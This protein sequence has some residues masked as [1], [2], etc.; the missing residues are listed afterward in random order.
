MN[1]IIDH[2]LQ[3]AQPETNE[4]VFA[5]GHEWSG[6]NHSL[7]RGRSWTVDECGEASPQFWEQSWQRQTDDLGYSRRNDVLWRSGE[8][9]ETLH[10]LCV[11]LE[12]RIIY[13][14]TTVQPLKNELEEGGAT[15]LL[16]RELGQISDQLD[17]ARLRFAAVNRVLEGLEFD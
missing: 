10:H 14:E 15:C 1:G 2:L 13:Q 9:G 17:S 8:N 3:H 12:A 5:G 16:E 11:Q 4:L 6:E 7:E